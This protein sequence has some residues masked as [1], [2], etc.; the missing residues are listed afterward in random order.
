V[1]TSLWLVPG[2]PRRT[3]LRTRIGE[4]AVDHGSPPFAPH[5]TL[6]AGHVPH[7]AAA[8]G[9]ALARV[10]ATWTPL[11]LACGPTDHGPERFKAVFIRFAD[12]RLWRV[13]GAVADALSV[14]FDA[15][16]FDP[17]LSLLYR[18]DLPVPDRRRLVAG[19]RFE[20]QVL[21]FDTL[22]ASRP[23]GADDDVARWQLVAERRL[24]AE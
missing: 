13:A 17:H 16:A 11:R 12:R 10:A 7:A 24:R 9:A 8:V 14:E 20:G 2:E 22:A 15:E 3:A 23:A 18:A 1:I 19:Q 4:L 5:I 6:V 21:T